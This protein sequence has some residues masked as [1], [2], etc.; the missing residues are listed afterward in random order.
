MPN[1]APINSN[2]TFL[3]IRSKYKN[4]PDFSKVEEAYNAGIAPEFNY[5][6]F[7][8]QAEVALALGNLS[9]N[10]LTPPPPPPPPMGDVSGDHIIDLRDYVLLQGYLVDNSKDINKY[11]ADLNGDSMITISDLAIL[12]DKL[13]S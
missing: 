1:N 5:H 6:K 7:W 8:V 13:L 2:S 11:Q 4:D 12:R 3:S 10:P 9:L